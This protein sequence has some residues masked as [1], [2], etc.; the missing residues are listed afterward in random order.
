MIR[1][2]IFKGTLSLASGDNLGSH[3]IGGFKAPSGSLRK[4]R[5]CLAV[6]D[7]M[8]TQVG[9]LFYVVYMLDLLFIAVL[10]LLIIIIIINITV[11]V[12]VAIIIIIVNTLLLF[13]Y[14]LLT[15]KYMCF[16]IK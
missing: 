4:C 7:N 3:Y 6:D 16:T 5:Q 2:K 11:V 10:L 9:A 1:E 14:I 12:V 15:V 13:Y 8:K